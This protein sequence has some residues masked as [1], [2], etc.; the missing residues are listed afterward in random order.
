[1][2]LLTPKQA[3]EALGVSLRHVQNLISEADTDT[4]RSRWKYGREIVNLSPRNSARRTLRVNL[5]MVLANK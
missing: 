5:E 3:A 4:K 1:V 2:P